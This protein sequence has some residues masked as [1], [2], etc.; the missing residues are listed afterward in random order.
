MLTWTHNWEDPGSPLR[1]QGS[2]GKPVKIGTNAWVGARAIVL[3]GV[4]VGASAVIGAGSVVTRSVADGV[5][6]AG[7]PARAIRHRG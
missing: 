4:E 2:L 6:A 3:P 1:D 7:S 5:I